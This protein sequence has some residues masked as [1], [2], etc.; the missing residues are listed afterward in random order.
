[1]IVCILYRVV[2]V[3]VLVEDFKVVAVE[4]IVIEV[5]F[6]EAVVVEVVEVVVSTSQMCLLVYN[7]NLKEYPLFNYL[8]TLTHFQ[9]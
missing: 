7:Y 8:T 1:M 5:V 3:D 4:V 2:N 6:V 9:Y